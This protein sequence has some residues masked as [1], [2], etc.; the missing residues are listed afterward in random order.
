MLDDETLRDGLQ[1]PSVIDPPIEKKRELLAP[2]ESAGNRH[3]QHRAP[4]CGAAGGSRRRGL[5]REIAA[6][7]AIEANCARATMVK[8]IDPIIRVTQKTGVPIE[9]VPVHRI[10]ADP[11]V[12]R[13][14]GRGFLV[15]NRPRRS[16]TR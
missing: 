12:R 15:R 3:R 10:V 5:C 16:P 9:S 4:G 1:S 2:H 7:A 13:R 11:A 14:V 6:A 8:D